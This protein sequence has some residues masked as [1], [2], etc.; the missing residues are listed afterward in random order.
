IGVSQYSAI[1][2]SFAAL[3]IF[4][5][6]LQ[7]SWVTVLMG[8]QVAYYL[9][10][11]APSLSRNAQTIRLNR[12]HLAVLLTLRMIERFREGQEPRSE[13]ILSEELGVSGSITESILTDLA[14]AGI[15]REVR[16]D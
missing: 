11:L 13:S 9:E 10:H 15:I 8:A 1:Y 5:L 16:S 2:G 4:L 14:N 12:N 7:I 6:W 3:P